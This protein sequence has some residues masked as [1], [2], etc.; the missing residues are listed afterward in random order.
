LIKKI[1]L[2]FFNKA[3][4]LALFLLCSCVSKLVSVDV[5]VVDERTALENQ[6][7]GSYEEINR[8]TL[9]LASVRSVDK[10]GNLKEIPPIPHKK[11]EAIRAI[12]RRQFNRDDIENFKKLGCAGENNAGLLT[13][14][15]VKKTRED[16]GFEQ[17]SQE[18]IKQENE[19]RMVIMKRIVA[20]NENFTGND[21]PRVQKIFASLNRTAARSGDL[22]QTETGE[23]IKKEER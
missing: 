8:D 7:L 6:V 9:L 11:R 17:F 3:L 23:W 20:T 1:R 21:L 12:Q 15:P 5:T 19:D 10:S 22:V 18:I 2:N 16:P 4:Y 13:F 14:F